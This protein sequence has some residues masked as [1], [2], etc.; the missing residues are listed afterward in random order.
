MYPSENNDSSFSHRL[1]IPSPLSKSGQKPSFKSRINFLIISF[2]LIF[3]VAD[4][5]ISALTMGKMY[6]GVSIAGHDVSYKT[7]AQVYSFLRSQ[8][9]ERNFTIKVGDKVFNARSTQLGAQYDIPT[10]IDTAYSVGHSESPALVGLFDSIGK[11]NIGYA[12][13]ID[14]IK[15]KDFTTSII[16]SAGHDAKNATLSI[17]DGVVTVLP[18]E[19][20]LR[21]D[22]KYLNKIISSSLST[23]TDQNLSMQPKLVKASILASDTAQAKQEAET[24]LSN[25]ISLSYSGRTF[26][27]DKNAIGHMIV[28]TESTDANGRAVLRAGISKEQVAG[29]VQSV[30]NQINIQPVNKKIVVANGTS[31]VER[32]G[33]D[34]LA[35]NQQVVIDAITLSLQNNQ[36]LNLAL[37]TSPLAFRTETSQLGAQGGLA[38]GQYIEVSLSRQQLWAWQNGQVVFSTPVTSGAAGWGFGTPTGQFAIYAKERSRYLN[39]GQY[40]WSYNVY[41]DYW[42]PFDGG[43]GLHDADWRS[44]FGGQDYYNGGSHG[45]VNMPKSSAAF[46]FG[47]SS[48]GTPVWVHG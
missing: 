48:I 23:A 13:D 8:K 27:A 11:G 35:L 6:P 3:F 46:L 40:G 16:S 47:W 34:G 12:Y 36:N 18:D 10:T 21:I 7:R 32:E 37:T 45:C 29:Y 24:Y 14:Q 15:L 4:L 42:M 31:T 33:K 41:V 2:L 25:S 19:D 20:G 5:T 22:Q 26:V 28:F 39:G 17:A 9:L 38:Y 44:S 1:H 43:V 30:A